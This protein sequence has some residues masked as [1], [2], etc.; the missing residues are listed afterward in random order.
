V[1]QLLDYILHFDTYL[2]QA[3]EALGLWAYAAIFA[4]I[5]C[6]TGLVVAPF[7]PGE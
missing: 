4:T 5:F 6:E 1:D 3:V 2:T 7:L